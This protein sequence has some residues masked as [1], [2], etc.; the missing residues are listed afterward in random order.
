MHRRTDA[1]VVAFV[2]LHLLARRTPC[3]FLCFLVFFSFVLVLVSLV[4]GSFLEQRP[5]SGGFE[6][7]PPFLEEVMAPT[8]MHVLALLE[9]AQ[10]AGQ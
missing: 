4:S 10:L 5:L 1:R 2:A 3:S 6:A 7:N 8:S 9:R